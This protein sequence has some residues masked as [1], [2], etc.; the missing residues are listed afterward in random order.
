MSKK[1]QYL[2][3]TICLLVIAVIYTMLVKNI[4]VSAIGPEGSSVGFSGLNGRVHDILP[5]NETF[6]KISKYAGILPF[7]LVILYGLIG[8]KQLITEKSLTKVDKRLYGLATFY[9]LFAAVYIFFEK[10]IIN[11]RPVILDEG[12]EASYPSS[13]TLLALCLC[14]SS[15]I[16]SKYFIENETL[17]TLINIGTVLLAILIVVARIISGVHW[18]TDIVG[19]IIISCTLLTFLRAYIAAV[20]SK[21]ER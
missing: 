6:Y 15:N 4:H 12:L 19:G 5:Y 21:E 9:G 16:V 17:R 2:I 3:S 20:D 1:K 7:A 8:L 11:Y 14:L 10:V 13:H 18:I